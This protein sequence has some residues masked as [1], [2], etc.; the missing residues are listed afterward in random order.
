MYVAADPQAIGYASAGAVADA[1]QR[2]LTVRQL[3]ID[4]M[5][6]D[7]TSVRYPLSR[8]LLL[9]MRRDAPAR[10]EADL[11]IE[12]LTGNAGRALLASYGFALPRR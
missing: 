4:G 10:R 5:P 11:L 7:G 1:R 12:Y 9:V 8:P 3:T 2:G 6:A